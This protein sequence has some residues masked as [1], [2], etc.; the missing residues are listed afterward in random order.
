MEEC[1]NL[2]QYKEKLTTGMFRACA[3]RYLSEIDHA[4]V[5]RWMI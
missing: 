2:E 1:A 3:F 4:D 5:Q